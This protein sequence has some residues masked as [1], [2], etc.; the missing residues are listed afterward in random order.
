MIKLRAFL[1][2]SVI[3][4][5]HGA[6]DTERNYPSCG[7]VTL[8]VTHFK[9][10]SYFAL[11]LHT[12][13]ALR[14]TLQLIRV[15]LHVFMHFL[16]GSCFIYFLIFTKKMPNCSSSF[17]TLTYTDNRQTYIQTQYL[18]TSGPEICLQNA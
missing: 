2:G 11:F 10:F 8:K 6:T 18:S 9:F 15:V 12:Q 4:L 1:F 14:Y 3:Y 17:I 5:S 13:C 7:Q 16:N